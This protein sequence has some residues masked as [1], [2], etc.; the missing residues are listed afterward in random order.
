MFC[1]IDRQFMMEGN[2][3]EVLQLVTFHGYQTDNSQILYHVLQKKMQILES[4][5]SGSINANFGATIT[6]SQS[7]LKKKQLCRSR[8]LF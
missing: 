2:G 7:L 1:V 6:A 8:V 4:R 5:C 3:R